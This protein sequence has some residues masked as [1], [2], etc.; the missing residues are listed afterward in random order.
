MKVKLESL[1]EMIAWMDRATTVLKDKTCEVAFVHRS[2]CPNIVGHQRSSAPQ[3]CPCRPRPV[4]S[5]Q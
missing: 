4:L 2:N 1:D 3:D 5:Y